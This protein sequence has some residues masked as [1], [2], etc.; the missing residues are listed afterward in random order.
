MNI[1]KEISEILEQLADEN[2]TLK[3]MKMS[4]K[5]PLIK[6]EPDMVMYIKANIEEVSEE[7]KGM[8][9]EIAS[10]KREHKKQLKTP[11]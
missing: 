5:N 1:E 9:K 10:L 8:K 7:I 4:L 3:S 11:K 2:E 6:T